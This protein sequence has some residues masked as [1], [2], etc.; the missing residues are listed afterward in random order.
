MDWLN[1]RKAFRQTMCEKQAKSQERISELA[2]V[3]RTYMC[4]VELGQVR[5]GS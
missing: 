1:L 5:H 3:Y 4:R 2:G